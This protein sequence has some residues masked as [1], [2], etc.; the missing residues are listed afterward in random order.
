[1]NPK[2]KGRAYL[3]FGPEYLLAGPEAYA[4]EAAARIRAQQAAGIMLRTSVVPL[5]A[6]GVVALAEAFR[7]PVV[8]SLI[9]AWSLATAADL[10]MAQGHRLSTWAVW[11]TYGLAGWVP[12]SDL[13]RPTPDGSSD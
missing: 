13:G 3:G 4:P 12:G 8:P 6:G 9:A 2:L 10:A 7:N 11:S 5:L 1:M